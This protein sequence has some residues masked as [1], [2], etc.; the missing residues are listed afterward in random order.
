[1]KEDPRCGLGVILVI[2]TNGSHLFVAFS[3]LVEVVFYLSCF[4]F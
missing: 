2:V 3:A 1:M 4:S